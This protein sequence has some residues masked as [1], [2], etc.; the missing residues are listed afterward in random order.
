[1]SSAQPAEPTKVW[2]IGAVLT[3]TADHFKQKGIESARLD[4]ELLLAHVLK[5]QRIELYTQFD[6]P[7]FDAE[8][9]AF[10][11]LVKRRLNQE[12][13]A[14]LLGSQGFHEIEL[15]VDRRVLIPRPETELLTELAI[16]LV[17]QNARVLD[18]GTG[19]GAI[20]LS[21]LNARPDLVG[22]ATDISQDALDVARENASMLGVLDRVQFRMGSVLAPVQGERFACVLSNP[23]YVSKDDVLPADVKDFE[24]HQAL[25]AEQQGLQILLEL[26]AQVQH[27]L[28]PGGFFAVELGMGQAPAIADAA[29]AKGF[30]PVSVHPD[31]AGIERVVMGYARK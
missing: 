9:T 3:W 27:V 13:V 8:L 28:E 1:M 19:S 21:L 24:P 10:R 7:L 6:Q 17:P 22:I 15:K 30:E 18:V 12:P 26:V 31:L 29:R 23:P 16:T 2:T 25:Y 11:A 20:L 4:A 14:Y 5:K